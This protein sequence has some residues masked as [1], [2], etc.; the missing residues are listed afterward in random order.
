MHTTTRMATELRAKMMETLVK[1]DLDEIYED[2]KL[3]D[4]QIEKEW[5]KVFQYD[6]SNNKNSFVGNKLLYHYQFKHL[7]KTTRKNKL[8][9]AERIQDDDEYKT[10]WEQTKQRSRAGTVKKRLFQA[11]QINTGSIVFFKTCNAMYLYKK[12]NAKKIL[13]PCAG[14]GGRG[15]GAVALG[16][17]YTGIDTNINLCPSYDE[18]FV[19]RENVRMLWDSCLNVDF[20]EIDFDFVLTSPPYIDL[21]LY[22]YMEAFGT[23]SN[24][25]NS[26]LIPLIDKCRKY[27]KGAVAI[28]IAPDMYK[29]LTQKYNYELCCITE[30]LKEHKQGKTADLVY[31]W[32]C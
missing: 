28:N 13:D 21:E 16:L 30:D 2:Y 24:F 26:F 6:C 17:Q 7:T 15:I 19:G 12:Y 18:M 1:Y 20:S 4:E 10:L 14:W 8:S 11:H 22:E 25:Y 31:I 32:E 27:C 9:F 29:D 5:E 23:K 3:T